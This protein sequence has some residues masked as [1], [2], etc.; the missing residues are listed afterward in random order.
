VW[1]RVPVAVTWKAMEAL[2]NE[3]LARN[4]GMKCACAY[5]FVL[6]LGVSN[7]TVAILHD[8]IQSSEIR[9]AVN[10]VVVVFIYVGKMIAFLSSYL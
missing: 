2:Y 7:F 10:Q 1:D 5:D 4:I 8:L 6:C 9:P 3:G